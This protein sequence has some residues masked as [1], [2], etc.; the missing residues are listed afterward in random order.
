[1]ITTGFNPRKLGFLTISMKIQLQWQFRT[2][3]MDCLDQYDTIWHKIFFNIKVL[4]MD[5]PELIWSIG[6]VRYMKRLSCLQHYRSKGVCDSRLRVHLNLIIRFI[7][8]ARL[9]NK[10]YTPFDFHYNWL[11]H[12]RKFSMEFEYNW[13][14]LIFLLNRQ[15]T[16]FPVSN[17]LQFYQTASR[18]PPGSVIRS[19]SG[20]PGFYSSASCPCGWKE[21]PSRHQPPA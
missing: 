10:Q 14:C 8:N 5:G 9:M 17:K 18:S 7:G 4:M 16:G 3:P 2:K 11:P 6:S 15:K 12:N 21:P 1:M 13:V 19:S 20:T